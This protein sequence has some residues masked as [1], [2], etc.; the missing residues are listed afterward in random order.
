MTAATSSALGGYAEVSLDQIS[1]RCRGRI[2]HRGAGLL[3]PRG[4]RN[5]I[6][7]EALHGAP[8]HRD[9]LAGRVAHTS[10]APDNDSGLRWPR[11]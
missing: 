6:P 7:D 8:D 1:S 11:S 3:A 10:T 9:A 2:G 5:L 4:T